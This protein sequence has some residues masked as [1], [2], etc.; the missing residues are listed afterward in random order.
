[1]EMTGR[2]IVVSSWA[3]DLVFAVTAIPAAAGVEA[4]E[5]IALATALALFFVSLPIWG[6]AFAVAASRS[7]QGDD[8]VIANMFG[9]IGGAPRST[10]IHLFGSL[11]LCVVVAIGTIT[12]EPFGIMVPMLPLG[13]V[14]LWAARHGTFPPRRPTGTRRA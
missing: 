7:A 10:R 12:T 14:G 13:F 9:S 8:I 4:F 1:M 3:G 2:G 5:G 11:G 6:W